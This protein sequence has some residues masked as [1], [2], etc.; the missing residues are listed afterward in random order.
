MQSLG[1]S[2]APSYGDKNANKVLNY[3]FTT[4]VTFK[5]GLVQIQP[6]VVEKR[7]ILLGDLWEQT[8]Y[9][10]QHHHGTTQDPAGGT[11]I[12]GTGDFN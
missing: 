2:V 4:T 11:D 12:E 6:V 10:E 7:G 3:G 9:N 8:S 1:A 5:E